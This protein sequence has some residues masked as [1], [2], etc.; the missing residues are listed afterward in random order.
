MKE[1]A[2]VQVVKGL[3][4]ETVACPNGVF[5]ELWEDFL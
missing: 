1:E 3:S 4:R 5:L 2:L